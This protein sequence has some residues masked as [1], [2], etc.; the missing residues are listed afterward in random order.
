MYL[1]GCFEIY[2]IDWTRFGVYEVAITADMSEAT[3]VSL[4]N[5][6]SG[7]SV[8]LPSDLTNSDDGFAS[9]KFTLHH[10]WSQRSAFIKTVTDT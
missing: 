1:F 2:N 7:A 9:G 8:V 10:N 6:F 5:S 3:V 4:R